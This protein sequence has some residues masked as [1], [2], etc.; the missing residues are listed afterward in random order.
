MSY[1]EY[2][3]KW[4]IFQKIVIYFWAGRKVAV[5]LGGQITVISAAKGASGEKSYGQTPGKTHLISVPTSTSEWT[6]RT[7]PTVFAR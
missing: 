6:E 4:K 2:G 7:P 1:K 3:R 5:L